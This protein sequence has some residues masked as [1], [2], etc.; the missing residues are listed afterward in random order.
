MLRNRKSHVQGSASSSSLLNDEVLVPR[1]PAPRKPVEQRC[2]AFAVSRAARPGRGPA[3]APYSTQPVHADMHR[4]F[5]QA[6]YDTGR[7]AGLSQIVTPFRKQASTRRRYHTRTGS[8]IQE[9]SK[10]MLKPRSGEPI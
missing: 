9:C 3:P 5:N 2:E 8:T 4:T 1:S 7:D 10:I 6:E